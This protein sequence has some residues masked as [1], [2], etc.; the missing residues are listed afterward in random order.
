MEYGYAR[1]STS[2]QIAGLDDQIAKLEAA[3]CKRI[4]KEHVSGAAHHRE[5][6]DRVLD[7]IE[8]GD[9]LTVARMDRL[10]RDVRQLLTIAEELNK[11][12]ASLRILDFNGET[13]DTKSSTGMLL[14]TVFGAF[15]AFERNVMLERQRPG[16]EKAKTEGKYKGRVPTAMRQAD[17][18]RAMDADG[19]T[20]TAIADALKISERS[21]YRAL[22]SA[23]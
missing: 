12:G 17:R 11:R 14:L 13:V 21:V 19:M 20:R 18:I 15:A 22:A 9:R 23:D 10:A 2:D 7:R 5:Q 16:I 1:T 3:G 8:E 6:L 4:Y